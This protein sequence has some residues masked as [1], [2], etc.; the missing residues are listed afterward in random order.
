MKIEKL[1]SGNYRIQIY[2]GKDESGKRIRKSFTHYDKSQL[3]LIAAQYARSHGNAVSRQTLSEAMDAF[4]RAKNAVLSPSTIKAYTS[5]AD[6][7][8]RSQAKLCGA[9]LDDITQRDLQKYINSLVED[10]KTPKTVQNYHGF[11]SAV[12]KYAGETLPHV[13]LPQKQ[14]PVISIPDEDT[15]RKMIELSK[16]T[17]L[18]IPILLAVMG[19]RRSEI[20]AISPEDLDG[21]VLHIHEAVVYGTGNELIEKTTKT[22]SSDRYI[23]I[24]DHLADLIREK[25]VTDYT[26]AGLS[27]AFRLFLKKNGFPHFRLH[28]MRHFFVSYCH[29]ILHLSDA[30]IQ[31]ITGHKTSVIMRASYLHAMETETSGAKVAESISDFM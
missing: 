15:V 18:E 2:L 4:I 27:A 23:R 29:N 16:D 17:R 28:D 8:K 20:C 5:M 31:A 13:T 19:L 1:P 9:W 25:G 30:Q 26:P 14:K 24:P 3:R 6:T 10:E 12:F 22:V 11:L 21:N 7:L